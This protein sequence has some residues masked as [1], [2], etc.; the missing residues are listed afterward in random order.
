MNIKPS[1]YLPVAL[2]L[3]AVQLG[4]AQSRWQ[5]GTLPAI[6]LNKGLKNGWSLNTKWESRQ[7]A[8][9]H[10]AAGESD[11][12]FDYL[13]SD[14]SLIGAKKTGLNNS[15]A[16]GYLIRLRDSRVI[17]RAIQQFTLV[18]RYSRF[19][20]AHRI[21]TDQTFETDE[22]PE[23]RLR[24]RIAAELPLN[25][26]AADPG[27]F[28]LKINHEYLNAFQGRE[29]DLE[30]RLVPQLGYSFTDRNKLEAGLDYRIRGF[31]DQAAE[32]FYWVTLSWFV[33][34]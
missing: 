4:T 27:E 25:G 19:R 32:G 9:Q 5:A 3:L 31:L 16:A 8:A 12:G 7:R 29:Y 28:Y 18:Q 34:I 10:R 17:H 1:A 21:A 30:I 11:T 33:K 14:F 13:L 26:E 15:I 6:N 2:L 22:L 20:L 24:Y 23:F